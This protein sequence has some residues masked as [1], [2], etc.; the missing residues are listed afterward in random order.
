[1]ALLDTGAIDALCEVTRAM[2][3]PWKTQPEK[4]AVEQIIAT[5]AVVDST[6]EVITCMAGLANT[7]QLR[8]RREDSS[9]LI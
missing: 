9:S 5:R 6:E 8:L 4:D 3:S 2:A 1:M 7:Q